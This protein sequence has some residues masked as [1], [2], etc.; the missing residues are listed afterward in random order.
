VTLGVLAREGNLDARIKAAQT[1]LK[2][3][4]GCDIDINRIC[5]QVGAEMALE[6]VL[7]AERLA[8]R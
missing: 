8:R 2:N 1:V 6:L 5:R 4:G 7:Q 3:C